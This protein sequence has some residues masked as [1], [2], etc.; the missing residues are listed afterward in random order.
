MN[1]RLLKP[2]VED[3]EGGMYQVASVADAGQASP[4]A[5]GEQPV[6]QT[7]GGTDTNPGAVSPSCAWE[8]GGSLQLPLGPAPESVNLLLR[9]S[10]FI[11][12][13][14]GFFFFFGCA[15]QPIGS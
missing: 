15:M 4:D 7:W 3:D 5:A 11:I 14:L 13:F 10:L 2:V 9:R 12:Y 6:H 8:C 1:Q